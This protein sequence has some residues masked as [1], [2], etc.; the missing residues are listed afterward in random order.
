MEQ[1]YEMCCCLCD[2]KGAL[3]LFH[4]IKSD[5]L[6]QGSLN[7]LA[8]GPYCLS[9]T[10]LGARRKKKELVCISNLNKFTEMYIL[11]MVLVNK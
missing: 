9:D 6:D 5:S 4:H 1:L 7:F 8:G 3:G 10:V 11:V 2:E